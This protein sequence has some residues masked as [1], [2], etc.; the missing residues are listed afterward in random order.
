L[1]IDSFDYGIFGETIEEIMGTKFLKIVFK[2]PGFKERAKI[3]G[4]EKSF[5]R[6]FFLM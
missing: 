2:D 1:A 4:L 5:E 3:W 6:S